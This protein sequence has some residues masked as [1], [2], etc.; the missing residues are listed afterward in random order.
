MTDLGTL[1]RFFV[2]AHTHW[3]RE[4]YLPFEQFQLRLARVVDETGHRETAT[5]TYPK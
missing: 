2:V 5:T 4:W 3:D 1:R